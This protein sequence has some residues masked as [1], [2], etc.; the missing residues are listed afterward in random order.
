MGFF[1]NLGDAFSGKIYKQNTLVGVNVAKLLEKLQSL[2]DSKFIKHWSSAAVLSSDV[3]LNFLLFEKQGDEINNFKNNIEK[4]NPEKV[5]M[6]I[7]LLVG[8]YL[9]SFK[10]NEGNKT[11]LNRLKIS[12]K[13]L[14][15]DIFSIFSFDND[16]KRTFEELDKQFDEDAAIYFLTLYETIFEKAY[17]MPD[18]KDIFSSTMMAGIISN[19][20]TNVFLSAL[21]DA[22]SE[23][24]A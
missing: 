19:T 1:S 21:R 20:Y 14:E 3:A 9:T 6:I 13:S 7:K 5:F 22:L 11:V 10:R 16:D 17:G 4:L 8:H 12:E 15:E 23:N 2:P 18:E 24:M